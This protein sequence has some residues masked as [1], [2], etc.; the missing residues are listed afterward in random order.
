MA[1]FEE[2]SSLL[3]LADCWL[4]VFSAAPDMLKTS[5]VKTYSYLIRLSVN[6]L[7]AT[8]YGSWDL[9]RRF[10]GRSTGEGWATDLLFSSLRL[11]LW[12]GKFLFDLNLGN[13]RISFFLCFIFILIC[14]CFSM[15]SRISD[16]EL[17]DAWDYF[18]YAV[19]TIGTVNFSSALRFPWVC[20]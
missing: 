4:S 9:T 1:L 6:I 16:S 2:W 17:P 8:D 18:S 14:L 5:Q 11:L 12:I 7:R 13:F 15:L 10:L 3:R 20:V 19:L